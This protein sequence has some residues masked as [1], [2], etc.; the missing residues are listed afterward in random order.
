[1]LWNWKIPSATLISTFPRFDEEQRIS[2]PSKSHYGKYKLYTPEIFLWSSLR[3]LVLSLWYLKEVEGLAPYSY[4]T[5]G[6]S[7]VLALSPFTKCLFFSRYINQTYQFLCATQANY[8]ILSRSAN[9]A[10][11]SHLHSIRV[12]QGSQFELPLSLGIRKDKQVPLPA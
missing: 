8:E 6:K 2:L 5:F 9:E 4:A 12:Y 7:S 3:V 11:L 1:M 10:S